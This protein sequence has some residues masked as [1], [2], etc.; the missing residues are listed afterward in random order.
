[1]KN[2]YKCLRNLKLPKKN[3]IGL[4]ISSF[5]KKELVVFLAL[6]L[7]LSVSTIAILQ[8]INKSFMKDIPMK[9]G[10]ISEGIVGTPRFINPILAFSDADDDMVSL[11]YSG[12]MR[13]DMKGNMILDLAEKYEI[14]KDNLSYT[15]T[16]K[17]NIYFHDNKPVTV[18]DIIFTINEVKNPIIK[19]PRKANWDG[20]NVEKIDD[21]TIKFTL[22][23]PFVSF[24][25]NL[26]LGI[27]PQHLWTDSPIE[28]NELNINP[29]GSGPYKIKNISKQSSG[30]INYYALVAFNKFILGKPYIQKI[31]L[32][33]YTNEDSLISALENGEVDQISSITP[34][35]AEILK[36]KNYTVESSVLPRVFGLFFNQN[37]NQI[38]A[39]KNITKAI[40]KAIDKDRIVSEILSGYGIAI[41]NPIP[42]NMIQYQKLNKENNDLYEE[43]LNEA[44]SILAKDG[45]KKG[46]DGFLE[47]TT[48]VKK[49]KTTARLEFSISTS[50]A[51]ELTKAANLIKENLESIGIKVDVKTFEVGNLNQYVIRPRKYETL[52]FGQIINH[53]S[54]LF[55]FWH[56]SQRKDPGLN[57][58]MY[59]NTKVDKILE[60]AFTTTDEKSRIKKYAQFEDEIQKDIPAIFL[61]SPKF[62]YVVS[63]NIKGFSLEHATSPSDRFLNTYLWYMDTDSVWKIFSK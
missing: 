37:Q 6:L 9:G 21:K 23:Q 44:Q 5:S 59:T 43:K 7:F 35:N 25:E 62:I 19:S 2:F 10:S 20:V 11:I 12:L 49:K 32:H 39:N 1:M 52:L 51:I 57:V 50:N 8:T 41:D 30:V 42:P 38:F 28:I 31:T 26:T 27:L 55:A 53:E 58:A 36:Q 47:K 15:F 17:Q 60:D 40:D 63:K 3:E 45:W 16:L 54:D 48:T 29:I 18:E 13:K 33:F 24:L 22:K 4:A 14:S 46:I 61:Y 34:K 56:S